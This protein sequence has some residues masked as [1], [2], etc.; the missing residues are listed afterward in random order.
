LKKVAAVM[1]KDVTEISEDAMSLLMNYGYPG[2][3]RELENIIER[4]VALCRGLSIEVTY[5]P[6]DLRE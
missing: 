2:N 5:L 6:E 1:K 3:V 4:G